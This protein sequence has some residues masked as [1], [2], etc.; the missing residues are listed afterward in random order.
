MEDEEAPENGHEQANN[1]SSSDQ[2]NH[3]PT[4]SLPKNQRGKVRI[5]QY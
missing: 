5:S 4:E 1:N 3:R 2:E